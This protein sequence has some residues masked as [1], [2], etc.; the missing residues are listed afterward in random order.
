[1]T[2]YRKKIDAQPDAPRQL[3]LDTMLPENSTVASTSP[4]TSL[5][6]YSITKVPSPNSY[7]YIDID[8]GILQKPAWHSEALNELSTV[9]IAAEEEGIPSPEI[10]TLNMATAFLDKVS[11]LNLSVPSIYPEDDGSISIYFARPDTASN[12]LVTFHGDGKA[13]CF[14]IRGQ[15]KS[16]FHTSRAS[17]VAN[18]FVIDELM[19]LQKKNR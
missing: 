10:S 1:M 16:R 7:R 15:I 11:F 18:S 5:N 8:S 13:S 14:S 17:E 12:F 6:I 9:K 4:Q 19:K 3:V 2:T